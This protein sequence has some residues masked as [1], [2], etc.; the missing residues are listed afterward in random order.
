MTK[1]L[2]LEGK[3]V[4][5][6]GGSRGIGFATAQAALKRGARVVLAARD[7]LQLEAAA[8]RL[9][10]ARGQ[11]F[12][13]Q[14]DVTDEHMVCRAIDAILA[15]AGAIDVLINN[16]GGATQGLFADL[17]MIAIEDEINLDYLGPLRVLK[18][19]LPHM[20]E[21][22]QGTVVNIASALGFVAYPTMANYSAAKAAVARVTEALEFEL[23]SDGIDVLLFVPGHTATDAIKKLKLEGPPV[24]R[25]EAV[26]E[27]IIAAVCARR[28][29]AVHGSGNK[30]LL[31]ISRLWPWYARYILRYMALRSLPPGTFGTPRERGRTRPAL[32]R[33]KE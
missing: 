15:T 31:L 9:G 19:V 3:T 12:V 23:R 8:R 7:E 26:G 2:S 18:A 16:A 25:P 1:T 17:P 29:F 28:R 27:H 22:G 13:Q 21:R 30:M 5:I 24:A 4:L 10:G 14:I 33:A 32:E 20:R 11:V 6:T